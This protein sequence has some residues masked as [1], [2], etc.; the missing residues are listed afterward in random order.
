MGVADSGLFFVRVDFDDA[1]KVFSG[2][3]IK[4]VPIILH[5]RQKQHNH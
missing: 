4:G 3:D 2:Y 5:V 1:P